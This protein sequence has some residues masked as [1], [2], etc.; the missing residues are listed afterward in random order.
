MEQSGITMNAN[1]KFDFVGSKVR[2]DE[3]ASREAASKPG[4]GKWGQKEAPG[5]AS[6]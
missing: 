5:R 2:F 4:E 1:S 6:C 3:R